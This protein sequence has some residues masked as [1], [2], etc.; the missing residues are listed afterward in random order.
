MRNKTNDSDSMS[1]SRPSGILQQLKA[2]IDRRRLGELLVT[3]GLIA[4]RDLRAALYEQKVTG[5]ALGQIFIRRGLVR[6]HQLAMVLVRQH[7]LRTAAFFV[8][9]ICAGIGPRKS[10]ADDTGTAGPQVVLAS[11]ALQ[12]GEAARFAL[13]GT[14]EKKSANLSAFTKW[15]TMFTRFSRHMQNPDAQVKMAAW[16]KRLEQA[17]GL[18]LKDMAEYVNNMANGKEYILDKRNWGQSDYWATPV[19]FINRGGDCEDFAIM[20]Y[21]SLRTLGVPEERLR[22]VIVQ[23]TLKNIPH[24]ILAVNTEDGIYLLDNQIKTLVDGDR[25]GRYEPIYSINRSAWWLHSAPETT[26]VA[27]R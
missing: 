7:V 27:S 15:N 22:V 12:G 14:G 17:R 4:P 13:M 1:N 23:D 21:I 26:Q 19:E 11:T 16:N 6:R 10:Q 8:L 2:L 25:A 24:A 5:E 9:F 20:K 18:S 3:T